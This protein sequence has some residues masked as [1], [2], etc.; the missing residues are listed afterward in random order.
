MLP[1]SAGLAALLK[2]THPSTKAVTA[3]LQETAASLGVPLRLLHAST[4]RE[5][6]DTYAAVEPGHAMIV[7]TDPFF[8]ANRTRLVALAARHRVPSIYDSRE[9]AEAGGLVSYGP[10][11]VRLWQEAG[12]YVARIL[13]GESPSQLPV[14]QATLFEL[15]LN[16]VTARALEVSVPLTLQTSADEVID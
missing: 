8:F 9:F 3:R 14:A 7:A 6:D 13:R 4:E 15:V 11:H 2:P 12:G 1:H 16:L 5:I 10:N